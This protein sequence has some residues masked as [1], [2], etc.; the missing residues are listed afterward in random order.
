[1]KAILDL[2]HTR[3]RHFPYQADM[4]HIVLDGTWVDRLDLRN[5]SITLK[6][7]QNAI[8]DEIIID[9]TTRVFNDS[10]K[11]LTVIVSDE[12]PKTPAVR[13]G[14]TERDGLTYQCLEYVTP[15]I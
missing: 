4:R 8:C 3:I 13:V 15:E 7:L 6:N 12:K 2:S 11:P 14:T 10:G 1:M 9:G 5:R